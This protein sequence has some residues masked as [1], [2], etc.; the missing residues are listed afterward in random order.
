[1]Q[2]NAIAILKD[3]LDNPLTDT[4]HRLEI[5]SLF[6]RMIKHIEKTKKGKGGDIMVLI[7]EMRELLKYEE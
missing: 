1:M 3:R 2:R 4:D 5:I 7:D 6:Q